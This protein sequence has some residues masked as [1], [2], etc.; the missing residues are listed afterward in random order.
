M[1]WCRFNRPL[2]GQ[3]NLNWL[4]VGRSLE[5]VNERAATFF[6]AAVAHDRRHSLGAGIVAA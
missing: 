2:C 1:V 6:M 4:A 3:G 5:A